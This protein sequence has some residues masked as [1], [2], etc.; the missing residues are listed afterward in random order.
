MQNIILYKILW[1]IKIEFLTSSLWIKLK[2]ISN[3]DR[4]NEMVQGY[5]VHYSAI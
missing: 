4:R 5:V 3:F 2:S 1:C